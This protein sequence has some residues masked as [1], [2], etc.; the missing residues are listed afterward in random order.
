MGGYKSSLLLPSLT[1][2]ALYCSLHQC[3]YLRY[4]LWIVQMLYLPQHVLVG[5]AFD[6]FLCKP[7]IS[8]HHCNAVNT[9]V[10]VC[11]SNGPSPIIK[12]SPQSGE[13]DRAQA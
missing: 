10:H 9:I 11:Q 12:G 2:E 7:A 6:Y 4:S 3:H 8:G 13:D 1:L 5:Y